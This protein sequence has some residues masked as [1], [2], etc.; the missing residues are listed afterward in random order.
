MGL[1]G[2]LAYRRLAAQ[3][4][5]STYRNYIIDAI[6]RLTPEALEQGANYELR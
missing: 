6:F 2:E 5:N 1:C 3:D 4:G